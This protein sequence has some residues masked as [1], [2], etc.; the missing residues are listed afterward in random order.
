MN[1]ALIFELLRTLTETEWQLIKVGEIGYSH[2]WKRKHYIDWV[3]DVAWWNETRYSIICHIKFY[4]NFI[5]VDVRYW[6]N[7]D[8]I[9]YPSTSMNK[10][11]TSCVMAQV[12]TTIFY[13]FY[14][15]K[16]SQCVVDEQSINKLVKKLTLWV[17]SWQNLGKL[18][19]IVIAKKM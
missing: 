16:Q 3:W 14:T 12:E 11:K 7:R 4:V 6:Q 9:M 18:R 19:F 10:L 13:Q 5:Y 17:I 15:K 2:I 1:D 8:T